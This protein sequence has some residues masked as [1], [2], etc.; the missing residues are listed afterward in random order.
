MQAAICVPETYDVLAPD[1]SEV[2][3][4]GALQG[5]SMIH[6]RLPVGGVSKAVRHRTVEELWYCLSG[7]GEV[8]RKSADAE[9]ITPVR[10]GVSLTIPLGV[11]FQFRNTGG[12]ALDFVIVTLPPWPGEQEAEAAAGVWRQE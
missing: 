8:W 9:Q 2:R 6:C 5:G 10:A 11:S 1:G 3:L 7:Q 4:L 12:E